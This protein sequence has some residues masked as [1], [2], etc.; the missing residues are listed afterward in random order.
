VTLVGVI[1]AD[2]SLHL[3]DFRSSERTFQLISQIAGRSGRGPDP[4][5]VIVQTFDPENYAIQSAVNHDYLGFYE[6]ELETRRELDYP[7]FASLVNVISRDADDRAAQ[8]RLIEFVEEFGRV[9]GGSKVALAGPVRAVLAKLRGEYRWHAVL[10]SP[11]RQ[12]MLDALSTLFDRSP[13]LR[14]RLAVDVDPASML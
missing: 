2:T 1:S 6:Q 3:P 13:E 5:E 9:K 14:R 7:P 4:G 12:S 11:D 8:K 10:R